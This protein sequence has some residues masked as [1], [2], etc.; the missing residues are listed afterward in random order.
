MCASGRVGSFSSDCRDCRTYQDEGANP[1]FPPEVEQHIIKLA[2]E[3]PDPCGRS[4]SVWD[5]EQIARQLIRE[6]LVKTI[7]RE[8]VRLRLKRNRLKPWRYKMWLSAKVV[9]D[10]AFAERVRDICDLYTRPLPDDEW[11]LCLDENTNLQPRPRLSQ[12]LGALPD[13]PV[14]IEHEYRRAGALNLFAAFHT[15]SG[16]VY[17][18]L[19]DRKRQAEFIAFLDQL[20]AQIPQDVRVVH[21]VLDNLRMH[22]G[23]QVQQWLQKHPRFVW[24]H[25]PVHC[26]WMNQ[27][28]QWFSILKRQRLRIIDFDS[29][30]H[31]KD[32]ILAFIAQW[33]ERAHPFHWTK[34][35]FEKIL[36]KCSQN[37]VETPAL[38]IAA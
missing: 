24:H 4:L 9:R 16:Q 17:G 36:A 19:A 34:R 14:R 33:N 15:R 26:S 23:K 28:E 8:T 25:P 2:C 5:C 1:L 37:Q 32:R 21:V 12:T 10:A 31:L 13:C 27:V 11:V 18:Y 30:A 6:A 7:S 29:K 3:R 20:D 38:E 35:S 22:T